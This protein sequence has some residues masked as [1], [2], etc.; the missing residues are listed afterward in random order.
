[1]KKSAFHLAPRPTCN[2]RV[3]ETTD[4][5][6][7]LSLLFMLIFQRAQAPN[8]MSGW[9]N[10]T[11]E[12]PQ[13]ESRPSHVLSLGSSTVGLTGP[14][15]HHQMATYATVSFP[16]APCDSWLRYLECFCFWVQQDT[17]TELTCLDLWGVMVANFIA[18]VKKT[19]ACVS[20][21][22]IMCNNE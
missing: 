3:W 12:R 21:Q 16:E 19:L 15:T 9:S 22:H 14:S 4:I 2:T 6:Q 10:Y 20:E 8:G 13:S 18:S 17:D 1:M 7:Q 11:K 5:H